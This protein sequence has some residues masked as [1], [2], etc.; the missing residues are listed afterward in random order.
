MYEILT[1]TR[2][3]FSKTLTKK[4]MSML[5]YEECTD[6][7]CK[8]AQDRDIQQQINDVFDQAWGLC[9]KNRTLMVFVSYMHKSLL[10]F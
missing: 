10:T 6:R 4:T 3:T 8:I 2:D 1:A 5:C 9:T 7:V